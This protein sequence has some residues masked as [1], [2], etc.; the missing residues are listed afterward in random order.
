LRIAQAEADAVAGRLRDDGHALELAINRRQQQ[1]AL[2]RQQAAMLETRAVELGQERQALESRRE[3]EQLVLE[4][5]REAASKAE[6]DRD[7][8]AGVVHQT[9]DDQARALQAIARVEQDVERARADVYAVVNTITALGAAISSAAAQRERAVESEQRFAME[10]RELEAELD[11][12]RAERT[13]AG[14]HLSQAQDGLEAARVAYA[15]RESELTSARIE[16]EWRARDVRAREQALAGISARLRSLE[17]LDAHRAGF[18][19]AARM[20]LV[21]ANG[22]VGQMGALAD[23]L[24]VEPR[25]ERAVEACLGDLLQHVL[26]ERVDQVSAGLR[27]VRQEHAGRCGFIVGKP[28]SGDDSSGGESTEGVVPDVQAEGRSAEAHGLQMTDA[29]S[30][31]VRLQHVVRVGGPFA[32][33]LRAAMGDALIAASFEEAARLASLVSV[34]VA[35]LEGDVFR[36]RHVV[37]GG[38]KAES[39]GILATKREIKELRDRIAAEQEALT[40][41]SDETAQIELTIAQASAAIQALGGEVHRQEKTIVSVEAQ[42]ARAVQDEARLQQ[43]AGLVASEIRRVLEEIEGL[44]RRQ[45]E[46]QDSISRLDADKQTADDAFATALQRLAGAR[47]QSETAGRAAT[48]ARAQFAAMVERC[49]AASAEVARLEVG[50]RDLEARVAACARD[51][52]QMG[53]QRQGLLAGVADLERALD[54]DVRALDGLRDDMRRADD[55]AAELRASVDTQDAVIRDARRALD[56]VRALASELD[57]TRATAESDLTHLAQQAL[58]AVGQPLDQVRADVEQME[59]AG[60]VE[61]DVRAIRAAEAVEPDE[62]EGGVQEAPDVSTPE[63]ERMTAE[64][65][66]AELR[67]RID[68]IGPVNMM[69]IEQHSELEERHLFLTTQRQDLVDSIAQTNE[70]ISRIDDTTH[71]RFRE[72]FTAINSNFQETFSTLFGGGRAGLSLLDE[73]NPLES[74]IDIVASPPG[75]RLQNVMLLSGGEKALAAIALMFAIFRYKPSPFCLLDEIDAPLDDANI[76]RFVELLRGM[77]DRTQFIIITHSRKTMEIADRLYGVTMEE[78]GVSKLISIQ[79]N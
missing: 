53:E 63:P 49:T 6:G 1:I 58:D 20:V 21:N 36:G 59:A 37:A 33:A 74:G 7:S 11:K 72:A 8:A 77:M 61:P 4:A 40:A 76:G 32:P 27:L 70:A 47:E 29:A 55:R 12:A 57:V 41:V 9:S 34:P 56:A 31:A 5:R 62:D 26:V 68:R 3:P 43:R 15:A 50:A 24:E 22:R 2:D 39:R 45:Q 38:E 25:Y 35:T 30:G 28:A 10:A 75:K 46:A 71:A 42:L 44:D 52:T 19:D 69:A 14:E 67:A 16:H 54:A 23:F 60:I 51:I 65:A 17:E 18:A 66:I 79:M 73:S 64:E 13:A 48:E 78:P